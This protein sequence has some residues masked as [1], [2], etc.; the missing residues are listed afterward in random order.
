MLSKSLYIFLA[1]VAGYGIRLVLPVF[2]VRILSKPEIG[3]YNQFFLMEVLVKT[4]F[5]M[6]VNQSLYYF[7]PRD[8]KNAGA[9]FINSILLNIS[10]FSIAY[11]IIFFFREEIA[12]ASGIS[13]IDDYFP[14]MASYAL[15]MLL[16]VCAESYLIARQLILPSALFVFLRQFFS[17]V[18]AVAAAWYFRSL[19]AIF[20]GLVL[21]RVLSLI[22]GMLY[23]HFKDHGFRAERYSFGIWEQIRYGIVLG[24]AGTLWTLVTKVHEL[25]INRYYDIETW[26]VYSQG[27]KQIPVLLL[28]AQSITA[29]ALVQFAHL[30]KANDW[31]GIR[32]FW[33]RILA[34]M[35]GVA[36]PVT[37]FFVLLA[38]PIILVMFTSEYSGSIPIFQINSLSMLSLVL[39]P[40]LVLRAM[41]RND[42]TLKVHIAF[43]AFMPLAIFMGMKIGGVT[44]IISAHTIMLILGRVSTHV[45]L[46][47]IAPVKL[48]YFPSPSEVWQFYKGVIRKG[49]GALVH[50]LGK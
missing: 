13:I 1:K 22:V 48:G 49:K 18:V 47:R 10:L 16:N 50:R 28:Y 23:I 25:A 31:E 17:S 36:L 19:E 33:N 5:Q 4:M 3:A 12:A 14:H 2:L 40:T 7:I 21:S 35:Y 6:G 27:L 9:Y 32:K 38:K 26:A 15:L 24:A 29:V 39:N 30:E 44:G 11:F 42:I 45:I 37:A 46:N 41:N 8:S 34:S 20:L 43:F